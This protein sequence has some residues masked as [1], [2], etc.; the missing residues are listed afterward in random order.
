M[1][2]IKPALAKLERSEYLTVRVRLLGTLVTRQL[3]LG[4]GAV[5]DALVSD[6]AGSGQSPPC[7]GLPRGLSQQVHM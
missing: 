2:A 5:V 1:G 3:M 6:A 4:Q 7:P